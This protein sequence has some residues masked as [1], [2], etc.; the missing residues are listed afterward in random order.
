MKFLQRL[1]SRPTLARC[2][3]A[4]VL[5]LSPFYSQAYSGYDKYIKAYWTKYNPDVHW[6]YGWAQVKQESAFNCDAVSPVG[7]MGCAQFMPGTWNDMVK[8]GVVPEGASPFDVKYALEAQAYYMRTQ[9]NGWS[10]KNRSY[11][12]WVNLSLAGYNAGRGNLYK[13][14]RLCGGAM[15]YSEIVE[16]LPSVTGHHHKETIGYVE[17]INRYKQERFRF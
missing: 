17:R 4:S 15:E 1:R 8:A 13:A 11:E 2:I 9:F 16:C 10:R 14:Q 3:T 6:G 12:S 7:A 5:L